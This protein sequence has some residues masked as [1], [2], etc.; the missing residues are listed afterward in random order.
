MGYDSGLQELERA[1]DC[2]RLRKVHHL[3]QLV[4]NISCADRLFR[5]QLLYEWRLKEDE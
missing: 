4:S 1:F 5:A 3:Y 2:Q